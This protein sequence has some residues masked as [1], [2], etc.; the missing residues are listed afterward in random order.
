MGVALPK[1]L[2]QLVHDRLPVVGPAQR[3]QQVQRLAA[4]GDVRLVHLLQDGHPVSLQVLLRSG[5][6]GQ[7]GHGFEAEV[8]DVRVRRLGKIAQQPGGHRDEL[9]VALVLQMDHEVHRLE[10]NG[11]LRVGAVLAL[12]VGLAALH[13]AARVL[14]GRPLACRLDENHMENVPDLAEHFLVQDL[15]REEL[16]NAKQLRLK[17]RAGHMVIDVVLWAF[18][19]HELRQG[20]H[21]RGHDLEPLGGR[22][23]PLLQDAE[24]Q[25]ARGGEQADV[26]LREHGRQLRAPHVRRQGVGVLAVEPQEADASLALDVLR[27]PGAGADQASRDVREEVI[28]ELR[29]ADVGHGVERQRREGVVPGRHVLLD[30]VD[31]HSEHLLVVGE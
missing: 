9:W 11:M 10:K 22:E 26:R 21:H 1:D 17:P 3:V 14:Q 12:R 24:H 18:A 5:I 19:L 28:R 29:A 13:L 30:A 25:A 23:G 15:H 8:S 7:P 27:E 31:H 6:R 4:D 2:E 16:Q 20:V